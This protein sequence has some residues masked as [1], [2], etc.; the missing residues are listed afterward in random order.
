MAMLYSTTM[1]NG[2]AGLV[3]RRCFR[4]GVHLRSSAASPILA[5]FSSLLL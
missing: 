3:K 4:I 1:I 5:S 2:N